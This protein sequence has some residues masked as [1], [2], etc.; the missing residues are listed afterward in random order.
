MVEVVAAD[1]DGETVML[2]IASGK[3]YGIDAVGSRIWELLSEPK[4][5][6]ELVQSLREEYDVEPEQC[7]ADVVDFLHYLCGEGLVKLD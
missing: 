6:S 1:M 5:M 7:R 3:Y 4:T 2:S